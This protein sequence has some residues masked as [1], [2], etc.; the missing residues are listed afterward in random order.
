[1][2]GGPDV[3]DVRLAGLA[4]PE[5]RALL[6]AITG[7]PASD[8]AVRAVVAE[9]EGSPF[10]VL[11]MARSLR[12][13]GVTRRVEDAV[14]R[15]VE[16][17]TDLRLQREEIALGLR[18]LD[19]LREETADGPTALDP[20]GTPPQQASNPYP[21][22]LAYTA[23]D[24]ESFF[25]REALVAE[26]VAALSVARWL[27]VVGPS[28]SGKSSAVR[29]GL[30]AALR[31]GA[32][33]GSAEWVLADVRPG[34]DPLDALG[35]ALADLHGTGEGAA[36]ASELQSAPLCAAVARG[37]R[38]R[39]LVLHVDQFEELWTAA[40]EEARVR[41]LDLLVEAVRDAGEAVSVVVTMRADYY[42]RTAEHPVL[43]GLMA[44]S[45]VL[46][47]SMTPAELRATVEL[48]ARSVGMALEP[49][50]AQ[51]VLDDV[52]GQP[53]ALP[54]LSTAMHET[55][56]RRRGRSLTLAGYAE[57]GGARR[58]I[59]H[60]ADAT[61]TEFDAG[62]QEIARRLLLRLAAP[63]A[64]G[65]DVSRPAPLSELVVDDATR[66][67]L[68]RLTERRL[69]TTTETSA[70]PAHE[71]LL[72][73]WPRLRSWL[74]ADRDGRRLHQ[75]IATAATEWES[76]GRE[77]DSLLR[78]ARLAA[79]DDWRADR[80]DVLSRREKE[81]LDASVDLRQR[82]LRKARR[83]TRRF[84]ALAAVLVLLL[85]G[86][87]VA[88]YL[89]VQSSRTAAE[90]A[91][92]AIARDLVNQS[93]TQ[94]E[95]RLD[96]AL[97]LAVEAHRRNPSFE[98]EGGLLTALDAARYF[99][100]FRRE[101]PQDTVHSAISVDGR[102][103]CVLT[104]A[105]DLLAFDTSDW[106]AD[107]R[108]LE[109]G[110]TDPLFL[111]LSP[112][113]R[114]AVY[115][116]ADGAH[117][118]DLVPGGQPGPV[119][120][121]SEGAFVSFS[122]DGRFVLLQR[123]SDPAV[124][125]V[126]AESGDVVQEYQGGENTVAIDRPGRD[127]LLIGESTSDFGFRLQRWGLDER[128][129]G[130][131]KEH[132]FPVVLD[133]AYMPDG[134]QLIVA[135][136]DG[137]VYLLDAETL[138]TVGRPLS[139]ATSIAGSSPVSI[140]PE[141]SGSAV[142]IGYDDGSVLV[143]G[144]S[145]D[146]FSEL[147]RTGPLPGGAAIPHW[148]DSN[149]FL[150]VTTTTAAE[151]D[152][153][154]PTPLAQSMGEPQPDTFIQAF[155]PSPDGESVL[156]LSDGHLH[157]VGASGDEGEL[158]IAIDVETNSTARMAVSSDGSR[159]AVLGLVPG[160]DLFAPG[161][162]EP[163]STLIVIGLRD[164]QELLARTLSGD[165]TTSSLVFSPG[166]GTLAFASGDPGEQ[167]NQ[168]DLETGRL[169][170]LSVEGAT[171]INALQYAPDGDVLVIADADGSIWP[172]DVDTGELGRPREIGASVM[173]MTLSP[174]GDLLLAT[175]TGL[176]LFADPQTLEI[177]DTTLQFGS[178]FA[179]ALAVSPDG[180]TLLAQGG[181]GTLLLWALDRG[182]ALGPPLHTGSLP[183][184]VPGFLS[185]GRQIVTGQFDR[186]M[187]WDLDP[188]TW[189]A[190]ACALAGRDLSRQ[191][192]TAFLPDEPYRRTCSGE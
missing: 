129:H 68:A 67:V 134:A 151:F 81:F 47:P 100:G 174:A 181:D 86:A 105:G 138:E 32:L 136:G 55:W 20:D 29:A 14:G 26:M 6:A 42:G 94:T 64:D 99:T 19:Q 41:T 106:S 60:L 77:D 141:P 147:F 179:S 111:D 62:Q 1:L 103:L 61:F 169:R 186:M 149:R 192:W 166:G 23:A 16:L 83:T 53:G 78:G 17:R 184:G 35:T 122:Q 137:A 113:G 130:D 7:E 12:R 114:R 116:A 90:R 63:A 148:L 158:D 101:L 34:S 80:E 168:L 59:A 52:A 38:G 31:K 22:L 140:T 167:V 156:Y 65:G 143:G 79:A 33:P 48:P 82:D 84:Q 153:R 15:A 66:E 118:L 30:Q 132:P 127:E 70:Q 28:G 117:L 155:V 146:G 10:Y 128:P 157:E 71:A 36:L 144:P 115:L 24:A 139:A 190:T 160:Q 175:H 187:S 76:A 8:D 21:G 154:R 45:Q 185:D 123:R 11:Q 172:L 92:E 125:V 104:S 40:P 159:V 165:L 95:T 87:G 57:T 177:G 85:V 18:Q 162:P 191:E 176:V 131:A 189:Q 37:L 152:A 180:S 58:A 107:A 145:P 5:V 173:A 72:R 164:G 43:A 46:V 109:R 98:T 49:G 96:T 89:A 93:R 13:R 120:P 74:D 183:M 126:D 44:E 9:A 170:D 75:Q 3:V 73:E 51:A 182:K 25:G 39:R 142:A 163:T 97:L 121:Q 56:E 110:I 178:P 27:A 124:V 161:A 2:A 135:A 171:F 69:V 188:D 4:E 119:L 112:D 108:V 50:L 54:L 102:T 150:S 133:W 88:A 91:T